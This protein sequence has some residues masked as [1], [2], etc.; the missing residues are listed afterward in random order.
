[1]T[2]YLISKKWHLTS[3][4]AVGVGGVIGGGR[5]G[6]SRGDDVVVA[7]VGEGVVVRGGAEAAGALDHG[8]ARALG[9]VRLGSRH[10]GVLQG[11]KWCSDKQTQIPQFVWTLGLQVLYNNI[12]C[13]SQIFLYSSKSEQPC[14]TKVQYFTGQV[15]NQ[16]TVTMRRH[17]L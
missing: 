12:L 9:D 1:M 6:H 17:L 4:V 14:T 5:A 3:D 8:L 7:V 15:I 11:R 2:N 13:I 10:V 16:N